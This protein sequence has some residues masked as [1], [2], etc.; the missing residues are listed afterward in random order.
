MAKHSLWVT[1]AQFEVTTPGEH[2]I[3]PRCFGEDFAL[4]LRRLLLTRGIEV[5]EPIQEDWG[6]VL[7]ATI[8][9]KRLTIAIGV[10]DDS[11]GKIPA[12][13]MIDVEFEKMLNGIRAWFK[14]VPAE[15]VMQF[16]AEL[17]GVLAEESG[18]EVSE[19]EP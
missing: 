12:V 14:P 18:I 6:W 16:M 11:I 17:R 10:M 19:E 2:F 3:N 13:W 7:L 8:Q 5:N 4:W 1:T 15:P 9:G